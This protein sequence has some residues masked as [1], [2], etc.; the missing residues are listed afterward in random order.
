MLLEVAAAC[1]LLLTEIAFIW[2]FT[3]VSSDV[4]IQI[5]ALGEAHSTS[6]VCTWKWLQFVVDPLVLEES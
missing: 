1:E 4:P 2:F 5:A 6:V 3:C